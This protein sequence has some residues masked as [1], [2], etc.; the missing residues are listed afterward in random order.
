MSDM[1]LPR[2]AFSLDSCVCLGV[3]PEITFM[4]TELRLPIRLL[5]QNCTVELPL[6]SVRKV[7]QLSFKV[8]GVISP[9]SCRAFWA[10][11]DPAG[12]QSGV[13][14]PTR[15]FEVVHAA[16]PSGLTIQHVMNSYEMLSMRFF[17]FLRFC[18]T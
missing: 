18:L 5:A 9:S 17:V 4:A 3:T 16:D 10:I 6:A 8:Q 15:L 13:L 1:A 7:N 11:C 14:C 12:N 2:V